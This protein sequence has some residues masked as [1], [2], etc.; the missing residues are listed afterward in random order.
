MAELLSDAKKLELLSFARATI[1][2]YLKEGTRRPPLLAA[3]PYAKKCGA[4]VTLHSK[5]RLRGCIGNM[6]GEGPLAL[7]IRDMAIA[8]ATGDP[9]F[10]RVDKDE[11]T[12]VDIE[13]SVLTP[14][15]KLDDVSKIEVGKHGILL[16]RGYHQGVLLPQVAS[17]YGWDRETFLSQTCQKAGL[18]PDAWK[19]SQ[20]EIF[21]FSAEVFGEKDF[22]DQKT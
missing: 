11:M 7:T 8:A 4:F 16:K 9:R 10:H 12:S 6:V 21:V 1:E 17:E 5:G 15:E 2:E 22:A 20:T 19:D 14:L 18:L 3:G 13:I